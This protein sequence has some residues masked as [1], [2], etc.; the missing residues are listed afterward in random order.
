LL[1]ELLAQTW[2]AHRDFLD[3]EMAAELAAAMGAAMN[4][5]IAGNPGR[6]CHIKRPSPLN[7]LKDTY[8]HSWYI[9]TYR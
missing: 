3:L 7:V 5:T 1:S 4:Q 6:V 2:P 8:D 9:Y